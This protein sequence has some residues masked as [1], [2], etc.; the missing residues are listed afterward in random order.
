MINAKNYLT[1]KYNM[2]FVTLKECFCTM[3]G[4]WG[5]KHRQLYKGKKRNFMGLF[6]RLGYIHFTY[7]AAELK[8]KSKNS[9]TAM[10]LQCHL[11]SHFAFF[12]TSARQRHLTHPLNPNPFVSFTIPLA[13]PENFLAKIQQVALFEDGSDIS[14][15]LNKA[16]K[17][18]N[19]RIDHKVC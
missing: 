13:H 17:T 18:F 15:A 6:A 1:C 14:L 4:K 16:F 3:E 9:T 8:E 11:K 2:M 5:R 10:T 19:S 12:K 7:Q